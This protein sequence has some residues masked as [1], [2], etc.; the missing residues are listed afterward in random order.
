MKT[1]YIV[2]TLFLVTSVVLA[3]EMLAPD[4]LAQESSREGR[5]DRRGDRQEARG[6]SG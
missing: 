4:A 2:L 6:T 5:Q 3:L 1:K